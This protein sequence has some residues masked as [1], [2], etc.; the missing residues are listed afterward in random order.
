MS[1][2]NP[3]SRLIACL[4]LVLKAG[5]LLLALSCV[6]QPVYAQE[7]TVARYTVLSP[8]PTPAQRNPL[9]ALVERP[10][11]ETVGSVGEAV[12]YLLTGSGYRLSDAATAPKDREPLLALPL[13]DVHRDFGLVSLRTALEVL[14]SPGFVLVEDPLHRLISFEP[15]RALPR[16]PSGE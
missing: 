7:I 8:N 13:P 9:S 11:P 12:D 2:S 3:G 16:E 6:L 15:C 5:V 10:V 14:A 1:I 4:P